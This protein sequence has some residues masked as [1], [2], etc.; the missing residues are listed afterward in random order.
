LRLEKVP[1]VLNALETW[2]R[3]ANHRPADVSPQKLKDWIDSLCLATDEAVTRCDCLQRQ[4]SR[5]PVSA[6]MLSEYKECLLDSFRHPGTVPEERLSQALGRANG[7]A[8][9]L[10][11]FLRGEVPTPIAPPPAPKGV[12]NTDFTMVNWFGTEYH[13]ALGVQSSAV[14]ALWEEWERSGLGLHQETIREAVDAERDRFRIDT[15]FRNHPAWGTMIRRC[16][17]GR[18]RLAPPDT[19]Q[20]PSAQ[21]IPKNAPKARRKRG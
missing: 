15:A 2:Q 3:V 17:D 20:V 11:R 6:D 7:A 13:F 19:P 8:A 21:K 4:H 16:G 1:S 18:Y 5:L 9:R 14:R 10:L 12:H